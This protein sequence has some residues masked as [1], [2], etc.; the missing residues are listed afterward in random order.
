LPRLNQFNQ[1]RVRWLGN[2]INLEALIELNWL[3]NIEALTLYRYV[4]KLTSRNALNH[5]FLSVPHQ[6]EFTRASPVVLHRHITVSVLAEAA[7]EG[8]KGIDA[9]G[10]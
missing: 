7:A 8:R 6:K 10:R 2:S 4:T 9:A 3:I 1:L 5:I